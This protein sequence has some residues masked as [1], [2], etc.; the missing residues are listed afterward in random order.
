M[1]PL[2]SYLLDKSILFSFDRS[3]F[4]RHAKEFADERY[5]GRGKVAVI[6]GGNS[7]IGYATADELLDHGVQV[8]LL[9][10]NEARGEIAKQSLQERHPGG[11]VV[12]HSVELD[13]QDSITTWLKKG[14]P[15][16]VD[17]LINNAG[18]MPLTREVNGQG[19]EVVW[20]SHVQGHFT[21][22]SGLLENGSLSENAR[23][24]TV[25]SGGMY[26]QKLDLN[27]DT[28]PYDKYRVYANAKRAQVILT[29][30]WHEQFGSRVQFSC[31]HP[32]W[33]KTEGVQ[34]SLPLFYRLVKHRLRTPKQGCDTIL[35]LALTQTNNPGGELWFD[36][37]NA[38]H[39]KFNFT[40]E[41]PQDRTALWQ[42]LNTHS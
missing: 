33:V 25:T 11:T 3:G 12:L 20:A 22:T 9:C 39:H 31:M 13:N 38:P 27:C 41:S 6:T 37:Q 34:H 30:L 5:N 15:K 35:W 18:G 26:L 29:Q 2:L 24:I 19:E 28:R 32:G 42:R 4:L 14:A 7:G 40:R 23:V 16:R 8:H 21:L 10:R 17:I 36:R 1:I